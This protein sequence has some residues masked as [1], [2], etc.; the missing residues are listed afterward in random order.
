MR[1]LVSRTKNAASLYVIESTYVKG[2]GR[3]KG[4]STRVVERLGTEKEIRER[5]GG[6]DPYE[7][8]K[9]HIQE[10]NA[11]AAEGKRVVTASFS[12]NKRIGMDETVLFRGGYLFLE[13]ICS[14]LGLEKTCKALCAKRKLEYDLAQVLRML[15]QTRILFPTSKLSSYEIASTFLEPPKFALHH[16][17]RALD[18]LAKGSEAIQAQVYQASCKMVP[19]NTA[20]LYYDC[21]NYY[22]EIEQ[23]DTLRK[24]GYSKEHRPNPIV[25]MGLF[26]DGNGIPLAFSIFP[27][28]TNEQVSLKP[29]EE[30]II[31]DF[32]LRKFVVCT[33]AGLGSMENR[34]FNNAQDRAYIHT[35]SLKIIDRSVRDWA[36]D[37][38][39]WHLANDT[40]LYDLNDIEDTAENKNVYYKERKQHKEEMDEKLFVSYSPVYK[41]Y[42]QSIRAG[43]IARAEKMASSP[44]QRNRKKPNDPNRFLVSTHTTPDGEVAEKE[45]V[46][47]SQEAINKEAQY[48]GFYCIATNLDEPV[49]AII[50][51][52]KGRWEIEESFRLL[53]SEFKARPVY[54]SR[55][56]RIHA[57]FLTC[58]LALLVLRLLEKMLGNRFTAQEIVH[59][60]RDMRFLKLKE[61]GYIP[62][63]KRTALTDALNERFGIQIDTE[64]VTK[65]QM[66]RAKNLTKLSLLES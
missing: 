61:E 23:E 9:Q 20:I 1:L 56:N 5:L 22:F 62:A 35:Q 50:R 17:Y 57:H 13:A 59:T 30:R 18:E 12:P 8:A 60:L 32:P 51:I 49:E 11:K 39:G 15:V 24:Y 64:I 3:G 34:V 21:T 41:A 25:Q 47:V 27:G 53:K 40:Q 10:L 28:S 52:N 63:Y 38:K 45:S 16:V 55:E 48:D 7:W 29:L 2:S 46:H 4:S 14:S 54:V 65:T 58:F 44:S 66:N 6:Q 33:D 37:K 31:R 26:M 36:L 19:R 43:Q 42:Q